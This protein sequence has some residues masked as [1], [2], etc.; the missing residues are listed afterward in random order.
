MTAGVPSPSKLLETMP[1]G[2]MIQS[3]LYL[4]ALSNKW[5][6]AGGQYVNRSDVDSRLA[7]M[8]PFGRISSG[9]QRAMA[10]APAVAAIDASAGFVVAAGP[11]AVGTA[12]QYTAD[13]ITWS[14]T[15]V[16]V[17]LGSI[18]H[19]YF[20]G[21]RWLALL[22]SA[23]NGSCWTTADNPGSTWIQTTGGLQ[24]QNT[25]A[26]AFHLAAYSPQLALTA[27]LAVT[28]TAVMTVPDASTTSTTRTRTANGNA[29]NI[30]W[31]GQKFIIFSIVVSAVTRQTSTD[32]ITWVD[33]AGLEGHDPT[34]MLDAVSDGNGTVVLLY[35]DHFLVSV[36]HG[37]S[38]AK[39]YPPQEAF[40]GID[41]AYNTTA[42]PMFRLWFSNNRFWVT[43]G[44]IT[45]GGP[46]VL[47][48]K[49]GITWQTVG[50][51]RHFSISVASTAMVAQFKGGTTLVGS[52]TAANVAFSA[53]EDTSKLRLP[54]THRA[55]EVTTALPAGFASQ[56]E[57]IKVLP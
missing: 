6:V 28:T 5:K 26:T 42:F 32:G 34:L 57:Y 33:V 17:P 23:A 8:F 41:E 20:C 27:I 55:L 31:T 56:Q 36:D 48:S 54:A 45:G 7:D 18:S 16:S 12:I 25:G 14:T 35:A 3:P 37:D 39:V 49:N 29:R 22:N 24:P 50:I 51:R 40:L 4:P 2:S 19:L 13:G 52:Y 44:I 47:C 53:V 43:F 38:F 1:L 10:G 21:F 46:S 9:A 11:A 15:S 30:V